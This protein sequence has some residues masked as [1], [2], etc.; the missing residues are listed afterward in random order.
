MQIEKHLKN[1][2]SNFNKPDAIGMKPFSPKFVPVLGCHGTQNND[3]KQNDTQH[4][5]TQHYNTL[6]SK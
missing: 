6:P 5:D 2:H 1:F 3:V 4:N